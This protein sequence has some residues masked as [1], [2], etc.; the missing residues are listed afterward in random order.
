MPWWDR[1]IDIVIN[2][3]PHA[4]HDIGLI[5]V[6]QRYKVHEVIDTNEGYS[7][8]EFREYVGLA[9]GKRR[10]TSA[11]DIIELGQG[12]ML[13]TLWPLVPYNEEQ[14]EDPNDG[15]I[16]QLFRYGDTD[17]VLTGDAGIEEE[18]QVMSSPMFA[19]AQISA[20][21]VL[22][23]GHHGSDT[24]TGQAW[25]DAL[26]PENTIISV[27][28]DNDYGHPSLLWSDCAN[29]RPVCTELILTAQY[30]YGQMGESR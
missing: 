7:T 21:D 18:V 29:L 8:A 5:P 20:I 12:A 3:H 13:T 15:S 9:E 1:S 11:G 26:Q 28:A 19:E 4:D 27:G 2:T 30:G 25:I 16:M 22:K 14:L 6:L 17:I 10:A 24:S 23:A